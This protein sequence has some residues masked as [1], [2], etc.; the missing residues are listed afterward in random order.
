MKKQEL[1]TYL[2]MQR[3]EAKKGNGPRVL[4]DERLIWRA[5]EL[6]PIEQARVVIVGQDPYPNPAF[7]TGLA[8][9]VPKSVPI[10]QCPPTVLN[11]LKEAGVE[12][13]R[14]G[15]LEGWARQGVL[16]LNRVL[17]TLEGKRGA[18]LGLGWE[19]E[20]DKVIKALSDKARP[21]VFMLWGKKA[22]E[23]APLIDRERNL[24]LQA[25]HPSP[26]SANKGFFGCGHFYLASEFLR[27][28]NLGRIRWDQHE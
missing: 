5:L 1:L 11:I 25:P 27:T 7:A 17:T 13:P 19:E 9:S 8:F 21:V 2:E 4:P 22:Q 3:R 14:S 26:L 6:T 15:S 28:N 24:V 18:H 23:V 16:L 10:S 20:T 12:N